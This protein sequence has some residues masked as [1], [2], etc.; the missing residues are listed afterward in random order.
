MKRT[1]YILSVLILIL[2]GCGHP[3][4]ASQKN[5]IESEP[6]FFD[7]K[8]Y[9]W[10]EN[11]WIREPENLLMIHETIK[12]FGYMKLIHDDLLFD[13][14]LIIQDIYIKRKGIDLLDSL[15]LTYNQPNITEKYYNEFWERRKMERNDSIVFVI[16]KEIN[17]AIKNKMG[18]G[19]LSLKANPT[20]VNDTL[21]QLL[22]IE[23]SHDTLTELVAMNDLKVL[24]ELGFHHSVYN[25]LFENYKYQNLDLNRDSIVQT[26]TTSQDNTDAWFQDNTK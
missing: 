25:L 7:L 19:I 2:T 5:Y 15:E 14:P 21:L 17:F 9:N 11:Q 10:L 24:K 1:F 26:L 18:S 16:I 23:F 20:N 12:K 4:T 3:K 13:N 22:Q 6:S 8:N